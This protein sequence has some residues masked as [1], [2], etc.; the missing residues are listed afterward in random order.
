MV[1]HL[2]IGKGAAAMATSAHRAMRD[3]LEET[4][5]ALI[6]GG[7]CGSQRQSP[8]AGAPVSFFQ[9]SKPDR[10]TDA[11]GRCIRR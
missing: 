3:T 5:A 9:K 11:R 7:P 2:G 8:R 4:G 10:V 1:V 6:T